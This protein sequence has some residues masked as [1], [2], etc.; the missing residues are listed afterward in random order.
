MTYC[1]FVPN[2]TADPPSP[3]C[4]QPQVPS[5]TPN[6][7][8]DRTQP[9]HEPA[10]PLVQSF[11]S[12]TGR[13]QSYSL[14]PS[15]TITQ[16]EVDEFSPVEPRRRRTPATPT[17]SNTSTPT[18][19]KSSSP[20]QRPTKPHTATSRSSA[21]VQKADKVQA[22]AATSSASPNGIDAAGAP[23][24][25][26]A[27]VSAITLRKSARVQATTKAQDQQ[28][29]SSKHPSIDAAGAPSGPPA[30]VAAAPPP[31][32]S[33]RLNPTKASDKPSDK[34]TKQ[35]PVK[36]SELRRNGRIKA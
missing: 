22:R 31:R 9:Q 16:E 27:G 17:K 24:G 7:S 10:S 6:S 33:A 13:S 36:P 12:P 5:P 20:P 3:D 18:K 11:V 32:S 35:D 28:A 8:P 15:Q 34:P 4:T 14:R 29:A 2:Q 23:S 1:V 25:S 26:P 30:D 21:R 19:A